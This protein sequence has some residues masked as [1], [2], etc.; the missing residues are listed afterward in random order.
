VQAEKDGYGDGVG[1]DHDCE[2]DRDDHLI[3]CGLRQFFFCYIFSLQC[4]DLGVGLQ[5]DVEHKIVHNLAEANG[6]RH[7]CRE[8]HEDHIRVAGF[9]EEAS[10]E[11][12]DSHDI[13]DD[14]EDVEEAKRVRSMS[15]VL[16]HV[17][18][19]KIDNTSEDCDGNGI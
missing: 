10:A 13:I 7:R 15:V 16:D 8:A 14:R 3:H 19:R 18:Y 12:E 17:G 4:S 9:P 5:A 6:A 11:V 2:D 1:N